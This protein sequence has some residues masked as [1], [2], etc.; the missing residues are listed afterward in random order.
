MR[1]IFSLSLTVLG[2]AMWA[3]APAQVKQPQPVNTANY[4]LAKQFKEFGLGGK[5]SRISLSVAPRYINKTDNFWYDFETSKGKDYYLVCPAQRKQERLFDNAVLAQLLCQ[6]TKEAVDAGKLQITPEEFSKDLSSFEFDHGRARY[7]YYRAT[8]QLTEIEKKKTEESHEPIYTWMKF[9]PDKKYILYAKNYNLWV[10]GN[11][12]EGTDTTEVQLTFDGVKDFSYGSS[13][14]EE[15]YGTDSTEVATDARW[16]PDS[17]HVFI[18]REDNRKLPNLWVVNSLTKKPTLETYKYEYPGDKYLTQS[19]VAI[20]DIKERTCRKVN[21]DKWKDQ[22]VEFVHVTP[23]SKLI[24]LERTKRT[25]DQVD[26]LSINT[27]TLAVKELI[28]EEDKPYRDVHAKSVNILNNGRDILYRSERTGWGHYYHYDGD[29]NLKNVITSGN[30]VAGNICSIDTLRRTI[31]LYGYGREKGINPHFYTVYSAHIDR[32]GVTPIAVENGQHSVDFTK[33]N[34][35]FIDTY[36]TV[37]TLP[38]ITLKDNRGHKVLSLAKPDM[39]MAYEKGWVAPE[40]FTVK[41]ADDRTDLYGVMYKPADFDPAK[42]YPIISV[43][44]PGPYFGFVPT[45]FSLSEGYCNTMAQL[46]FIVIK[47]GHRGDTPM[48]GK[49]YHVFGYGNMRDYPLADDKYAIEQLAKRHSY[50]DASRVGIYGHSG[51]GFMAAAAILTYPDFYKAAVSCSGNH[52]NSVY[53]RGWGEC[54]NGIC[55]IEHTTTDS[56][57]NKHTD[58]EYKFSV[59][60]NQEIAKNLKGHLLLVT[61]DMDKNV[62]PANTYRLAHALIEADKDFDMLVIPGAGHGYGSA[63]GYFEQKMYRYFAK[64]LLGDQRAEDWSGDMQRTE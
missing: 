52:D 31:Y 55:E 27:S 50:I 20:V 60:T 39:S 62:N 22:Y 46:G 18:I 19:E 12:A 43:V 30:W 47:V 36:S 51:G 28:H 33:S 58:Y 3:T 8:R 26:L 11:K 41:A 4:A 14:N 24:F 38:V 5:T 2:V 49:L 54:Y 53:N 16:C 44:Y 7:R 10:K 34:R 25:W 48:R 29:G 35:Y 40:P 56:L 45:A 57:G 59:K 63:D 17:R 13:R 15:E 61:G 21:I 32:E 1:H 6:Q 23:D 42:K 9:S 37:N 64:Y